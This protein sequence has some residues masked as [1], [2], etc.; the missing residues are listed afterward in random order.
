MGIIADANRSLEERYISGEQ[1]IKYLAEIESVSYSEVAQFL[2]R[3]NFDEYIAGNTFGQSIDKS[4]H[5]IDAEYDDMGNYQAPF[6]MYEDKQYSSPTRHF[7]LHVAQHSDF[8]EEDIVFGIQKL[9]NIFWKK[10]DFE[11]C[12]KE[13]YLSNDCNGEIPDIS[14]TLRNI[15]KSEFQISLMASKYRP[16]DDSGDKKLERENDKLKQENNVLAEKIGALQKELS[17]LK[18]LKKD[19]PPTTQIIEPVS[20]LPFD[21]RDA[22][23]ELIQKH[24]KRAPEFEALIQT[25]KHH[26]SEYDSDRQPMKVVVAATFSEQSGLSHRNRRCAEAARILGLPE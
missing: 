19:I 15:N 5:D 2:L 12:I 7:L 25:L 4:F 20:I 26:E 22:D 8:E 9:F 17:A 18:V 23:Y 6:A 21:N 14:T 3:N 16:V 1:S 11:R 24:R 13:I 10:S